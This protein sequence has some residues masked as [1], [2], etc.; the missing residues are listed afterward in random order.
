MNF[1]TVSIVFMI[2]TTDE[3]TKEAFQYSYRMFELSKYYMV[4]IQKEDID[5]IKHYRNNI[6]KILDSCARL[7]FAKREFCLTDTTIE[8]IESED[9]SLAELLEFSGEE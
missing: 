9:N 7:V 6:F 1:V 5:A 8:E 2:V 3:F 4:L